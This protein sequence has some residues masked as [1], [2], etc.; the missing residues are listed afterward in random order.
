MSVVHSVRSWRPT[1]EAQQGAHKSVRAP[2]NTMCD[3]RL[4]KYSSSERIWQEE[5]WAKCEVIGLASALRRVA[6]GPAQA[7]LA[8]TA[9]RICTESLATSRALLPSQALLLGSSFSPETEHR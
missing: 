1:K 4:P 7:I 2:M 8:H 5:M 3:T 9:P 6:Q